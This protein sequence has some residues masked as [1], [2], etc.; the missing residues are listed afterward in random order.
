MKLLLVAL[1]AAVVVAL[2]GAAPAPADPGAG[3]A[4]PAPP[5]IDHT[6]WAQW[7]GLRSLRVFPTASGRAASRLPDTIG[8]ADEAWGEVL[9][10][11]PDADTP[12]MRAQFLCHWQIAELVQPGKTSWNLEPWRPVVDD[13]DMAAAGCNPGGREEGF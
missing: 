5:F 12:G 8:S 3:G 11:S 10:L 2:V 9:A 1:A 6:Q 7:N 4:A 13:A